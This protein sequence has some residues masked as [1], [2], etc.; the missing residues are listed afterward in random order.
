MANIKW[1]LIAAL[2]L[3]IIALGAACR[4]KINGVFAS[5][6]EFFLSLALVTAFGVHERRKEDGTHDKD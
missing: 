5:G 4:Y 2:S 6:G 3:I 1:L